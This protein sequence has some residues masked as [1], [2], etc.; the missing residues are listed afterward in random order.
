[1]FLGVVILFQV[2]ADAPSGYIGSDVLPWSTAAKFPIGKS[3][4]LIGALRIAVKEF[5]MKRYF[6]FVNSYRRENLSC[7]V[8][9][10]IS[11]KVAS[12]F[13]SI[14][15]RL[16]PLSLLEDSAHYTLTHHAYFNSILD[17]T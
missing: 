7:M 10:L 5:I 8:E 12:Y 9:R 6:I 2:P 13:I 4:D 1:M 16:I 14:A 17:A 3:S 11:N 15:V